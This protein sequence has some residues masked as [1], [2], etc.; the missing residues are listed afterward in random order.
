MAGLIHEQMDPNAAPEQPAPEQDAITPES[1]RSNMKIPE[2]LQAAYDKVVTAGLKVMFDPS[3]RE[4]T[5]QFMEGPGPVAEKLA[6]GV[7]GVMLL[8]Y[9]ESNQSMPPQVMIPAGLELLVHAAEVAGKSGLAVE[10]NDIAEGMADMV[11]LLLKQFGVD[12]EQMQGMLTQLSGGGEGAPAGGPPG[13]SPT[14]APAAQP[15]GA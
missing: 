5:M 14:G 2:G 10:K 11:G 15:M 6:Q 8:L 13:A 7:T 12:P 3:T 4:Q 9:K 1:V